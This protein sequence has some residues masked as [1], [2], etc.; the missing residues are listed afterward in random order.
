MHEAQSGATTPGLSGSG[1]DGNDD[2]FRIPQSS[3]ITGTLPSDCLV[4]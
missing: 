2:L 4:S 3:H 1:N